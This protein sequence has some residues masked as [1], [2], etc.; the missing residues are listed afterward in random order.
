MEQGGGGGARG[1]ER[2]PAESERCSV[3]CGTLVVRGKV[4]GVLSTE[5]IP[6]RLVNEG[7]RYCSW[8]S[9]ETGFGMVESK[10]LL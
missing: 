4:A 7:E 3:M 8:F 6:R 2:R 1:S 10:S 9:G 5:C